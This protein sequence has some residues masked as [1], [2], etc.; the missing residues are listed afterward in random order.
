MKAL[1]PVGITSLVLGFLLGALADFPMASAQAGAGSPP[2]PLGDQGFHIEEAE[3]VGERF[4]SAYT[5]VIDD[6]LSFQRDPDYARAEMR[7]EELVHYAGGLIPRFQALAGELQALLA[8]LLVE[9]EDLAA[10]LDQL[11]ADL[12]SLGEGQG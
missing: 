12:E 3:D 7:R 10:E 1:L 4:S 8:E 2:A 11:P 5:H 9:N 6:L